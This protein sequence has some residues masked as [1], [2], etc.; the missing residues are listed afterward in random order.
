MSN[1]TD[2]QKKETIKARVFQDYFEKTKYGYEPNID[3]VDFV[4]TNADIQEELFT[5]ASNSVHYL[6]AQSKQGVQV[7]ESMLTQLILTCKKTYDNDKYSAPP[8]IGCFD[9]E[10]IAF[11]PFHDILPIF[12]ENDFN[13]NIMPDNYDSLDFKEAQAKVEKRIMKNLLVYH[14]DTDEKEIKEFIKNHFIPGITTTRTSITKKNFVRIFIKWVKEV[15]PF[16]NIAPDKW[17]EFRKYGLLD[18]DFYHADL[19]SSGGNIINEKL[20]IVLR[21]NNYQPQEKNI[22]EQ[23]SF[24][25]IDFTD[26]GVAYSRFW[27]KYER[28]PASEYQYYIIKRR[29]LL[30]PQNIREV[31]GSFFTP[32]NWVAKSQK[33]IADVFGEEWQKEYYVWDC[34]AGTGNLFVGLTNKYNI[35]A[36]TIDQSDVDTMQA[37]IDIDENLSL[38]PDHVF[39]FDFLN[40]SFNKLPEELKKIINDPVKREKLIIYINPPYPEAFRTTRVAGY[41]KENVVVTYKTR[42]KYRG[43]V[44]AAINE[45]FVQFMAR[46][47]GEIPHCKLALFSRL[48]FASSL[49]YN[50]FREYFKSEFKAGFIVH[51]GTFD[52]VTGYFPI[53]FTIWNL[54]RKN[55]PPDIELDVI[56]EDRKKKFWATSGKSINQWIRQFTNTV[57]HNIGFMANPTPNSQHINQPYFTSIK[58]VRHLHYY[59]FDF[60][61]IIEGSIY[62]A[63]RLCIETTWL[64]DCDQFLYPNDGWKTDTEF[65]N[66]CL[67]FT[68]FHRQNRISS[69]YGTNHWIPFT[70]EEVDAKEKFESHFMSN[71]I[72]SKELSTEAHIVLSAGLRFWQYYHLK[73]KNNG[74]ISVN[75]SFYDM[76]EYF[77]GRDKIGRMNNKS[78]D[79]NYNFLLGS[80]RKSLSVLK[81]KIQPKIYEYGFIQH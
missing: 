80:V 54:D 32:K 4:I 58:G 67:I 31:K 6:W 7:V 61:N 68:L 77:Q 57:I 24:S 22:M 3:N 48:R 42:D 51:A 52:N 81:E 73:T 43:S 5:P 59:T 78:E 46:I 9:A 25:D 66:N 11:L 20:K 62:L 45:L 49:F 19:M 14:F 8:F 75:A 30:M 53:G 69:K 71:F 39:Q 79:E 15:K 47:Y 17:L 63:V 65:Q 18:C 60:N 38:L 44:G 16:I 1:Y 55:F 37:L 36:S 26:G 29:D 76:R 33:Y 70:E 34:A 74:T 56:E 13:W 21:N 40:D 50:K 27:N 28:P 72:K 12:N 23:L 2:I 10:K 41:D 64:S 35:W